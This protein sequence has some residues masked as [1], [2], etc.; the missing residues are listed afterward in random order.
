M[1]EQAEVDSSDSNFYGNRDDNED[2][3]E[4]DTEWS[5]AVKHSVGKDKFGGKHASEFLNCCY[6]YKFV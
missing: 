3:D 1:E 2:D 4:L 5:P 6:L